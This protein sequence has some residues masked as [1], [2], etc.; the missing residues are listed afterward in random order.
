MTSSDIYATINLLGMEIAEGSK[1]VSVTFRLKGSNAM[2]WVAG[3]EYKV[4]LLFTA[5][6]ENEEEVF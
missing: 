3:E 2:A 5:A 1:S 6:E 4:D